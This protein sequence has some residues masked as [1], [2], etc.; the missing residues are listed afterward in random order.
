M[1]HHFVRNN[2]KCLFRYQNHAPTKAW[3]RHRSGI[4]ERRMPYDFMALPHVRKCTLAGKIPKVVCGVKSFKYI[5]EEKF[6]PSRLTTVGPF[7]T[8]EC[9]G[10]FIKWVK[11]TGRDFILGD[12]DL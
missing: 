6:N 8:N 3:S 1:N 10:I 2:H 5:Y 7:M 4:Q 12:E 9:R 11:E